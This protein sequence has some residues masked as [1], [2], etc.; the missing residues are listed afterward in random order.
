MELN[1][2]VQADVE[3]LVHWRRPATKNEGGQTGLRQTNHWCADQTWLNEYG[4]DL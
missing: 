2:A 3:A 1:A 4:T